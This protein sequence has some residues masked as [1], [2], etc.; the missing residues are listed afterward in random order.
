MLRGERSLRAERLPGA[1]TGD[2][3]AGAD[4]HAG[5]EEKRDG[6]AD[7]CRLIVCWRPLMYL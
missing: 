1:D 4:A 3:D 7:L 6:E 2:A 5:D